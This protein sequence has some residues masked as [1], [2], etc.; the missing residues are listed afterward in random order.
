VQAKG[1]HQHICLSILGSCRRPPDASWSIFFES[2][3]RD[4]GN[5]LLNN[6]CLQEETLT[7][8]KLELIRIAEDR[9]T[10]KEAENSSVPDMQGL[11]SS[12]RVADRKLVSTFNSL[13]STKAPRTILTN[14]RCTH[15]DLVSVRDRMS[16]PGTSENLSSFLQITGRRL[17]F[18][19]DDAIRVLYSL[20]QS[21]LRAENP[22][23]EELQTLVRTH[24]Q[25]ALLIRFT[26]C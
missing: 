15:D 10:Q 5:S 18:R 17:L 7:V 19:L 3:S 24:V 23:S 26:S 22:S 14:L 8:A 4:V 25:K 16:P 13:V 9:N 21:A 2:N 20:E 11:S 12:I 1:E 6:A